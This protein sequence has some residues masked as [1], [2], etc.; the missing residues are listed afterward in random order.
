MFQEDFEDWNESLFA[1][2]HRTVRTA[3]RDYIRNNGIYTGS[4]RYISRQLADVLKEDKY[5]AWP[6]EEVAKHL[7]SGRTLNSCQNPAV[8][9]KIE[10]NIS[11]AIGLT[12]IQPTATLNPTA[13]PNLTAAIYGT[14][15][16]PPIFTPMPSPSPPPAPGLTAKTLTDL[17]KLYSNEA[18]FGGEMYNI[19]DAK[20]KIFREMCRM[21]D[22]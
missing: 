15:L 9:A 5:M 19:L 13:A 17:S 6:E 21:T 12:V 3:V 4:A 20:L 22:I 16:N 18:K 10:A 1:L 7:K 11:N 2:G 14:T 8:R